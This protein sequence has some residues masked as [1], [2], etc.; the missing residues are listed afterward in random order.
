MAKRKAD[1]TTSP[2]K[3]KP[4]P[5]ASDKPAEKPAAPKKAPEKKMRAKAPAAVPPP[6]PKKH[7]IRKPGEIPA[8]FQ[9]E[10]PDAKELEFVLAMM[11]DPL[12]QFYREVYAD[13]LEERG[14]PRGEFLR[15]ERQSQTLA[16]DML[17]ARLAQLRST[18]SPVWLCAVGETLARA[19]PLVQKIAAMEPGDT[20]PGYLKVESTWG[21]LDVHFFGDFDQELRDEVLHWLASREV[22]PIVRSLT[23]DGVGEA[24]AA[25]GT[26][27]IGLKL[28]ADAELGFVHL[29]RLQIDRGPG[30]CAPY[31]AGF[32]YGD[33]GLL[34]KMLRK[35]P[36]L[37]ELI[38]PSAPT[39]E[40]FAGPQ[41]PL[42][43]LILDAGYFQENFIQNLSRS[44]RFPQLRVLEFT[45]LRNSHGDKWREKVTPVAA[46]EELLRSP[47]MAR[48]EK[49]VIRSATLTPEETK[50]LRAIRKTGVKFESVE[51]W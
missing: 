7:K 31:D 30:F 2:E 50:R 34:A 25:N 24:V 29:H 36:N 26:T 33:K 23:I 17:T 10:F 14:S 4:A 16:S 19:Q 32:D 42:E 8:W 51:T 38:G 18:L 27:S 47:A 28:L 12:D 39:S 15:L 37:R 5:K 22:S 3:K 44:H 41:H 46:Y 35:S 20:G 45:D 13:W 43:R 49:I 1:S 48:V 9:A 6:P 40:F 21:L 11:D